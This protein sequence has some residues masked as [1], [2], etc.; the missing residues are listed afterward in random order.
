MPVFDEDDKG[1]NN[2]NLDG[3]TKYME[4]QGIGKKEGPLDKIRGITN[5]IPWLSIA[6]LIL[7][8][9]VGAI[10]VYA[11][12]RLSALRTEIE[13]TKGIKA[14]MSSLQSGFEARF[15]AFN[16]E[17]TGLKS[18]IAQLRNELETMKNARKKADAESQKKQ[19]TAQAAP[20][21]KKPA[22]KK[23]PQKDHRF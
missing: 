6:L 1:L 15:E 2:I 23:P 3:L 20:A 19:Q 16:R 4:A 9:I 10:A 7:I 13:E 22:A 11:N 5:R 17:K 14:E 21:K 8:V 18:E 12:L